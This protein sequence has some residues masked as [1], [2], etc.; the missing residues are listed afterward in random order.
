M[1]S[2]IRALAEHLS[3]GVVLRRRLPRDLGAA[4]IL[5]SP[6][7]S[8]RYWKPGSRG[9]EP[10]LMALARELVR[11]RSVVWDVGASVGLFSFAAAF[12]S[13]RSGYVL[14]IEA[15][16]W[17]TGLLERSAKSLPVGYA[18]VEVLAAAVNNRC[19]T[20]SLSISARGRASN[21]LA[22][23]EGSSFGA[24]QRSEM[25]VPSRTLN[26]LLPQ[27][28]IPDVLKI[29]I[30]GAEALALAEAGDVLARGPI[31]LCEVH[32]P[33]IESV[34]MNLVKHGYRLFDAEE[35]SRPRTEIT[36][37]AF[38]TLALPPS[39]AQFDARED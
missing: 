23:V 22:E 4:T 25:T 9:L 37:A 13:G 20:A 15:D 12:A 32:D 5:V 18:S 27:F 14:A 24:V 10:E 19:G 17:L 11:P 2:L 38:N 21:H 30:E 36:R 1:R 31:V 34:T 35:K 33:N 3:R 29:D 28:P 7:V 8:L 16:P 39:R 26:S 6:D